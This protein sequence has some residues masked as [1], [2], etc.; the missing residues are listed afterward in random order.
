M[1]EWNE[2]YQHMKSTL[3]SMPTRAQVLMLPIRPVASVSNELCSMFRESESEMRAMVQRALQQ[4]LELGSFL[5]TPIPWSR[6]ERGQLTIVFNR[7]IAIDVTPAR[8]N[9]CGCTHDDLLVVVVGIN[10]LLLD[11]FADVAQRVTFELLADVLPSC[12]FLNAN[13]WKLKKLGWQF[14]WS[15][16]LNSSWWTHS[17]CSC[18]DA[19]VWR[20]KQILELVFHR[21][22]CRDVVM[23]A[24]HPMC[25]GVCGGFNL[26][27]RL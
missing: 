14:D 20:E 2:A 24:N 22:E 25:R 21:N 11:Q 16:D 10:V 1:F 17:W 8:L 9:S 23:T 19:G 7:Q 18:F 3:P 27:D 26:F 13:D 4:L 5:S 6:K 15:F 12:Q